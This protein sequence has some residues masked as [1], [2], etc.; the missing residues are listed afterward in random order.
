MKVNPTV[1]SSHAN[2]S[3]HSNNHISTRPLYTH[4]KR[5]ILLF[6]GDILC[7]CAC[8]DKNK[9]ADD[10]GGGDDVYDENNNEENVNDDD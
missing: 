10:E 1:H 4:Q 7:S 6:D 9:N 8:P 5:K 3:A 2:M